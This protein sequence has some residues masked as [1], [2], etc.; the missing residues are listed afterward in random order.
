MVMVMKIYLLVKIFFT[1][2]I[3]TDRNDSGRG[4]IMLG[5]GN[6]NFKN[7]FMVIIVEY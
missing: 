1:V 3:E 4:L 6:G 2:Q 7:P 5:D